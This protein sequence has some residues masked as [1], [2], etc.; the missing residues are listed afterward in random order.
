MLV[1]AEG[2]EAAVEELVAFLREG[3]RGGDGRRGRGRAGQGRGPRAVRDPRRQRRRLR[4]P[5]ARRDG[6]S[7]RSA[8]RGRRG[9]ALLGGPEGAVDGPGG[10]APRGPGR[11]SR[12]R[13]Q[14]V[15]GGDRRR[16]RV[17]VWDRGTLRAGRPGR[18]AG[19]ARARPRR[20]RPPRREAARRLRP[21][22]HPS[23][24]EA[25][26][27][28]DQAPRRRRAARLRRRRRAAARR[29]SAAAV[30]RS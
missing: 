13:P 24:R 8:A 2:P 25:P 18:L 23:R 15:R 11:G 12:D 10:Q 28:A 9:D 3:P 1:H 16:A 19:G 27:A 22:A 30:W 26:V 6:A 20:L 21:A 5:G 14:R 29:C 4:R 7:L 17:I